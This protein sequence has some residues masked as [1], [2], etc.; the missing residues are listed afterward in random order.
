[1]NLAKSYVLA[2][3]GCLF[4]G[5]GNY[6]AGRLAALSG[7]KGLYAIFPTNF[8]LWFGFQ[9]YLYISFK[10]KNPNEKYF[11]KKNNVYYI[12]KSNKASEITDKDNQNN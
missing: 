10:L 11:T 5:C 12:I 2:L 9:I 4:L 1:M 3:A 6:I 8:I 7:P